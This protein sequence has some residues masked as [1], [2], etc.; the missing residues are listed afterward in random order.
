MAE[1]LPAAASIDT[2][3]NSLFGSLCFCL[4]NVAPDYGFFTVEAALVAY[5][6]PQQRLPAKP[7]KIRSKLVLPAPFDPAT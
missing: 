7:S 3:F 2:K 5:C 6:I 1:L 4:R